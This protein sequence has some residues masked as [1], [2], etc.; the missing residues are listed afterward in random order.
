MKAEP[1]E[2]S[3]E[4]ESKGESIRVQWGK[5][6]FPIKIYFKAG[7]VTTNISKYILNQQK[8]KRLAHIGSVC[9]GI[10]GF[11][12]GILIL[13]VYGTIIGLISGSLTGGLIGDL[14]SKHKE[15]R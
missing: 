1:T 9:G 6:N 10:F 11:I 15:N 14:I 3:K 7:Y 12:L 5:V 2:I 13:P 8:D 4:N